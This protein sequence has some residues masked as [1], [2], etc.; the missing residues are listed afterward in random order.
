MI[1]TLFGAA[2]RRRGLQSVFY[3]LRG[4]ARFPGIEHG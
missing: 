1:T 2:A 4:N 3:P